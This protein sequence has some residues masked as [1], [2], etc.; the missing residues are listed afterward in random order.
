MER[1]R[2]PGMRLGRRAPAVRARKARDQGR[3]EGALPD[4]FERAPEAYLITDAQ[5]S[6]RAANALAR[7]LLDER[8]PAG[9]RIGDLVAQRER[10]RLNVLLHGIEPGERRQWEFTVAVAATLRRIEASVNAVEQT[11]GP[12][13]RWILRDVTGPRAAEEQRRE[14]EAM[15]VRARQLFALSELVTQ[16]AHEL[17]QPLAAIVNYAR[18]CERRLRT[19]RLE[20]QLFQSALENIVGQAG[21]AGEVI[22]HLREGLD[23]NPARLESLDLNRVAREAV[24]LARVDVGGRPVLVRLEAARGLPLVYADALQTEQV[25]L[26]LIAA[27]VHGGEAPPRVVVRTAARGDRVEVEVLRESRRGAL[28]PAAAGM[29][30]EDLQM[31]LNLSRRLIEAMGGQL[32]VGGA[33]ESGLG[34]SLPAR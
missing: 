3:R 13:L 33:P 21:R 1:I 5:G 19:Q 29:A 7:I 11:D 14:R 16:L 2:A 25:L 31:E 30:G 20:T 18:G 26:K 17:N 12:E 23:R 28:R 27:T 6:V 22:R 10:G 32:Q 34:F 8:V 15:R 9:A 4:L 24:D